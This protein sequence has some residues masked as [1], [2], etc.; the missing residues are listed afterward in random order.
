[1]FVLTVYIGVNVNYNGRFVLARQRQYMQAQ[2]SMY[3]LI[4]TSRQLFLPLDV[5]FKLFDHTIVLIL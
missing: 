1:M 4:K 3:G 5:I 2:T